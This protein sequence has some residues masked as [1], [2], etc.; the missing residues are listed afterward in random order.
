MG[1]LFED[2]RDGI[3]DGIALV[4]DKTDEYTKIGKLKVEILS[5]K[6]NIEKLFTELG[7]RT[8]EIMKEASPKDV[9]KDEEIKHLVEELKELEEKLD[10]KKDEIK[11]VKEQKEAQR[12]EREETK[13]KKAE[14]EA[15][16]ESAEKIEDAQVVEETENTESKSKKS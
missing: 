12:K 4:A 10:A 9:R 13:K 5:I 6:R 11:A 7:G 3:R 16:A 8:Y 1:T 14:E 2:I 15:E